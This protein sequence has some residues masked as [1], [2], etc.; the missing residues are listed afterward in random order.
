MADTYALLEIQ[1]KQRTSILRKFIQ[2]INQHIAMEKHNIESIKKAVDFGQNLAEALHKSLK[3]GK[4]NLLDIPHVFPVIKD[5]AD[6]S[7][8]LPK[9]VDELGDLSDTEQDELHAYIRAKY[10]DSKPEEVVQKSL[11]FALSIYSRVKDT[12]EEAKGLIQSVKQ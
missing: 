11:T 8:E 2:I 10:P 6:L 4:I 9:L 1:P 7:N 12:V 3:D 5:V